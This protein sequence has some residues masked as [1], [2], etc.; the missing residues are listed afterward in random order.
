MP[1]F[2]AHNRADGDARI[3]YVRPVHL[4][5]A[6]G[7]AHA[8]HRLQSQPVD[9]ENSIV[10]GGKS[11]TV[12]DRQRRI[13]NDGK[14]VHLAHDLHGD[15][16]NLDSRYP[17][18]NFHRQAADFP[19]LLNAA[20]INGTLGTFFQQLAPQHQSYRA[21]AAALQ[22]YV[23]IEAK[24]SWP[25]ITPGPS[26]RPQDKSNRVAQ[27][28]A[29]LAA[30][31]YKT[32]P[33]EEEDFFD[34]DLSQA[35]IAYQ[36][37]NGLSPDGHAG[38]KT[39]ESLNVPVAARI[40]QI[41]ANMERWRHI[42][43]DFPPQ[44]YVMVNIPDFSVTIHENG[45]EVYNGTVIDGRADRRTPFIDSSIY[46]IV[47]N[48]SWHVPRSIARKDILPKLRKDP[49]YLE[50][51]GIVIKGRDYDPS[52][53]TIDWKN[54]P[55]GR[56][57]YELRQVP[58]DLNSLGQLKFNFRNPFDV[59]MHGTPHQE[60]FEKVERDFS[61]GCVRLKD[62]ERVAE[63]LLQ[64]NKEGEGW[65]QERIADEIEE[66]KTRT[67]PLANPQQSTQ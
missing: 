26:L 53:A 8:L 39:Q 18:W 3:W 38:A 14:T 56:F 24:D 45:A 17:G 9:R 16:V 20:I 22:I 58:G 60:L 57:A 35:L 31:G 27:L 36:T 15:N 25:K 47:F 65:D 41:R 4:C 40:G 51:L 59:Y 46:N 10:G 23:A 32:P 62:P 42:P 2:D 6:G 5:D 37:H 63:I 12:V 49:L 1:H 67:L 13:S 19:V 66:G 29:R 7:G 30:E 54:L 33:T 28:R 52:G 34:D 11:A 64:D 43:E 61:S 44:R 55:P 21:L 50:R 48:P